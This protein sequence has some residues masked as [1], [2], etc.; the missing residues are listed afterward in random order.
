MVEVEVV[1]IVPGSSCDRSPSCSSTRNLS[2]GNCGATR[3]TACS[4]GCTGW[5]G[6]SDCSALGK[7][8]SSGGSCVCASGMCTDADGSCKSGAGGV[9][10][11]SSNKRRV[12][13][14]GVW[15]GIH[16]DDSA[17]SVALRD[18][19][20]SGW[21]RARSG[22]VG[23]VGVKQWRS[24]SLLPTTASW[25]CPVPPR[26]LRNRSCSLGVDCGLNASDDV[27]VCDKSSDCVFGGVCYS[28]ISDFSS[29]RRRSLRDTYVSYTNEVRKEVDAG[30]AG[31][32]YCDGGSWNGPPSGGLKGR[33]TNTSGSP[34][35]GVKIS[36]LGTSF[37]ALTDNNGYY[38]I[39]DI[40]DK[41]LS[42]HGQVNT[43]AISY[44]DVI[45]EHPNGDY[46]PSN[47][48]NIKIWP[49]A[50]TTQN[51]VLKRPLGR[52][53]NDDCTDQRG[54]CTP[55]CHGK[56]SCLFSSPEAMN[57]C[58]GYFKGYA[59]HRNDSKKRVLCCT[60]NVFTPVKAE[61]T[62]CEG[63]ENVAVVKKPVVFRGKFANMVVL[64]FDANECTDR[65]NNT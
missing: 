24:G 41:T 55:E 3:S 48:K 9:S 59:D 45:A 57:I 32:E 39:R 21:R 22:E 47:Y 4:G 61:I 36:I 23:S 44:N 37:T 31:W 62:F 1:V 29:Y 19:G 40:P 35:S 46:D 42:P 50:N 56:G 54:I 13:F 34:V 64:A 8:C 18:A 38:Y 53:C 43:I 27:A 28:S 12:C 25:V 17:C 30:A 52:N 15:K 5:S 58:D 11:L 63:L 49:F 26:V 65:R 33:V 2:D 14:S 20:V 16:S 6:G 51:F 7:V 60:G 10:S